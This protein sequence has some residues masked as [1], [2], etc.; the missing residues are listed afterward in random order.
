[1]IIKIIADVWYQLTSV[2]KKWIII[3]EE[4]LDQDNQKI[5]LEEEMGQ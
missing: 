1:M 3:E 5:I 2:N 4:I